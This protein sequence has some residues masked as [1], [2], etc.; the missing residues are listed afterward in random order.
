V[1]DWCVLVPV[2]RLD[3]AKTRLHASGRDGQ[4]LDRPA[5]A[6]AFASDVVVAALA[7]EQ[8]AHVLVVTDDEVAART[9]TALGASVV[10]DS[11]D[12]GINPALRHGCDA[13]HLRWPSLGIAALSSDVPSAD[14]ATIDA[15]LAAAEGVSIGSFLADGSGIG[16]TMLMAPRAEFFTPAF[17]HRSRAAHRA[18]GLRELQDAHLFRLRR[19]VDTVVDLWDA[20]RIG[21]GPHTRALLA[22]PDLPRP[23]G[24]TP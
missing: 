5:A 2:K 14:G 24:S 12:A 13:A 1:S 9:L 7:A 15:A 23:A 22:R 19:D 8:V 10:P 16:T 20:L 3:R 4:P 17:G 18:A 21:V 11:P 6:L